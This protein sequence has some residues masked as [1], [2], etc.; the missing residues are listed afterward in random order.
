MNTELASACKCYGLYD[1][2]VIVGFCG[3][4]HQP[5]GVNKKIKRCSRIVIL[6]DYQGIGLGYKFLNVVA[7]MYHQ[8]GYS[9]SIVTS[10]KNFIV[11]LN[12]SKSW[13]MIRLSVNK[14]S[15]KKSAIDY[16]RASMRSRCKA[17]SF[18]YV[19]KE[20]V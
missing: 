6:P 7:D 16:K 2:D 5:H 15:S 10:A 14:C 13:N 9:F 18:M 20:G 11:K 4:L 12:N 1:N 17:A 19:G 8:Q 3:I